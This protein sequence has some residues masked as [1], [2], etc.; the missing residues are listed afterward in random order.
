MT[1]TSVQDE[2][3]ALRLQRGE[4]SAINGLVE[5]HNDALLGYLYR[6]TG[7]DRALAEDLLQETFLRVLRNIHQYQEGRPFKAWLY[8]IA[9]NAAR[10]HYT[11]A[12]SRRT[13]SAASDDLPDVPDEHQA[14]E[15][16]IHADETQA[17][18]AALAKL[19]DHQREVIVLYYYQSLSAAEIADALAVPV[20]TVKSRLSI[21]IS[22]LRAAMVDAQKERDA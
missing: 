16:L 10:N 4:K 9:T 22:R 12:E 6:M 21:G 15:D 20:G 8:A 3:W 5:R 13:D 19:P 1:I 14:D 2:I 7:G 17:V 18:I 11:S